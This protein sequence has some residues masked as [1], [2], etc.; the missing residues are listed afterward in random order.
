MNVLNKLKDVYN[1]K[2]FPMAEIPKTRGHGFKVRGL[3]GICGQTFIRWFT[4]FKC[5]LD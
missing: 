1:E 5:S 3:E 4:T 2:P